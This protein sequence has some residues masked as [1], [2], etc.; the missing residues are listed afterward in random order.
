MIFLQ[1]GLI[2]FAVSKEKYTK[3]EAIEL[4][5]NEFNI[6]IGDMIEIT[7]AWVKHRAGVN[8]NNEPIVGWWIEYED[9]KRNCPAWVMHVVHKNN[10]LYHNCDYELIV[11]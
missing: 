10:A 11:I 1:E 4:F 3:Q 2:F 5:K 7:S 8:E 6:K 9:N